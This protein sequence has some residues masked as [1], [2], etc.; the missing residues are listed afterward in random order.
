MQTSKAGN[1][2]QFLKS[3]DPCQH[4]ELSGNDPLTGVTLHRPLSIK[5]VD[6]SVWSEYHSSL[7]LEK[8][9]DYENQVDF[10]Q[11][12]FYLFPL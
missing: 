3:L 10:G 12:T 2:K 6:I 5:A 11:A 7:K 1:E 4:V 9:H 8:D